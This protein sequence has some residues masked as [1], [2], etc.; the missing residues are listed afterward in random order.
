YPE[1]AHDVHD[2]IGIADMR[3]ELIAQPLAGRG[4]SHEPGDVDELDRRRQYSLRCRNA[5]QCLQALIRYR[6]HADIR[7]DRAEGI[8]RGRDFRRRQRIEQRRLAHVRQTDNTNLQCHQSLPVAEARLR[9]CSCC[10]ARSQ[11]C[12]IMVSM[13]AMPASMAVL[14]CSRSC[15]AGDDSTWPSTPARWPG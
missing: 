6:H 1:A 10:T 7:I 12:V 14:I 15:G 4:A 9:L 3:Q 5:G 2:G 8:I 13:A 11:P